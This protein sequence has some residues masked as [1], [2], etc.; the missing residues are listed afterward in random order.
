M[1]RGSK[2]RLW[3]SFRV[4]RRDKCQIVHVTSDRAKLDKIELKADSSFM[5]KTEK[6]SPTSCY[7][8]NYKNRMPRTEKR[9]S[10]CDQLNSQRMEF[11]GSLISQKVSK[12]LSCSR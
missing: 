4:K 10:G 8:E 6:S 5:R 12:R 9:W 2:N 11:W 7:S 1:E 3:S